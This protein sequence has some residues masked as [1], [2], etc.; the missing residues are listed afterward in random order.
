M[1][2]VSTRYFGPMTRRNEMRITV[3]LREHVCTRDRRRA[4]RSVSGCAGHAARSGF[5]RPSRSEFAITETELRLI[6][7]LAIIGESSQP[8]TG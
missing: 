4:S 7:A 2:L 5:D 3:S 6:A 1:P 8:S